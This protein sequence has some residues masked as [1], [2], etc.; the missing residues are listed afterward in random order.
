MGETDAFRGSHKTIFAIKETFIFNKCI[1]RVGSEMKVIIGLLLCTILSLKYEFVINKYVTYHNSNLKY[2][3]K[4][5]K[6]PATL[7]R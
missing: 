4:V 5:T 2:F 3:L 6:R 1:I 7:S